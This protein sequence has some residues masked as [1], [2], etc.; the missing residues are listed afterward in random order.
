M[1]S[2][3]SHL[4]SLFT[5]SDTNRAGIQQKITPELFLCYTVLWH[6]YLGLLAGEFWQTVEQKESR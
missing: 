1:L 4:I 6:V 5:T 3:F 2:K